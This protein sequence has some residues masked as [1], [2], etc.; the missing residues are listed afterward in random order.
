M[1]RHGPHHDAQKSTT[2][3]NSLRATKR[4]KRD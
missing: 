4:S 2:T 3:G 1:T